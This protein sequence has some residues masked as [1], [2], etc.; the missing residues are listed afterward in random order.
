MESSS[1]LL[2]QETKKS[3]VD[4]IETIQSVWSKGTSLAINA[5]GASGE[6]LCWWNKDQYKMISAIENRNW[7][8]IKLENK[9]SQEKFWIRNVYGPTLNA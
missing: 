1:I 6:L 3:D 7:I 8:L 5:N 9:E 2:I 4:S